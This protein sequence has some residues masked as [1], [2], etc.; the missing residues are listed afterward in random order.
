M[1]AEILW[2]LVVLALGMMAFVAAWKWMDRKEAKYATAG[3]LDDL[4]KSLTSGIY[5][6]VADA[7]ALEK[8]VKDLELATATRVATAAAARLPMG[9]G[10]R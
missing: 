6:R 4:R 10:M 9:L 3:A 2:P 7:E 1:S 8:R 5:N